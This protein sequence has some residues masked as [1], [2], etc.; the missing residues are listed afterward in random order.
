M[1][2][3]VCSYTFSNVKF[4]CALLNFIRHLDILD[5]FYL[6]KIPFECNKRDWEILK[7]ARKLPNLTE[8]CNRLVTEVV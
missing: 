6:G 7:T 5:Y 2:Y 3:T 1:M 8:V 4:I